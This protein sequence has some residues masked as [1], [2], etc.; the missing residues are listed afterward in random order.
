MSELNPL[1]AKIDEIDSQLLT[2]LNERARVV[3]QI[4]LVKEREGLPIYAPEREETLLRRLQERNSGPL[5][6]RSLRAIYR[7]IMSASLALEKKLVVACPGG[8]GGI[9]Y[10]AA[11]EKFGSSIDYHFEPEVA[12]VFHLVEHRHADCGVVPVE[13][14]EQGPVGPTFDALALTT[15]L[16][17]AEIRLPAENSA[18]PANRFY[19]IGH[20]MTPPSGHDRTLFMLRLGD[21]PSSLYDALH[22]FVDRHINLHNFA[23]RPAAGGS[24]D[25]LFFLEADGHI[26]ELQTTELMRELSKKARAVKCLGSFPCTQGQGSARHPG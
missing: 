21:K 3:R 24:G 25:L 23:S 22:P 15:L 20:N 2:L 1:R 13:I 26:K 5:S 11:L 18:H 12:D 14:S 6:P 9:S 4:G 17:C 7:E 19:V 10:Q 16:V 8:R